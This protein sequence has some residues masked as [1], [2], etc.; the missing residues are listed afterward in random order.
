MNK[1]KDTFT[2]LA[3]IKL[4]KPIITLSVAFSALTGFVL[5]EQSFSPGW[6]SLYFGVLL[7]AAGSSVINQIQERSSDLLMERTRHRPL[8]SGEV[9]FIQASVWA[10]ILSISGMVILWF[11]A[12]P[13]ASILAIITLVWYNGIY[14][15]LK[16]FTSWAILPG[17]VVGAIP[18]AIGWTAAGNSL[19]HPHIIFLS[20]FF[21]IGQIPHFWLILLRYGEDYKKAGFPSI[22]ATLN[23]SQISRLTF[24][25]ITST[26]IA[27]MLLPFF[28]IIESSTIS[29][30]TI[31]L[32]LILIT[33][34][35]K[36]PGI[37]TSVYVNRAF[38]VMNIYFLL[39]MIL[40][41]TD[42]V[43]V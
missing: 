6:I 36:W 2:G 13:T 29:Y 1:N 10:G 35:F 23:Y 5:A 34:F 17:A 14:T 21:F 41:I 37:K 12:N 20:F 28:G 32:S 7:I 43:F 24:V 27:A 31:G 18:P 11:L 19:M 25:W 16:K 42:S 22:T 9:S 3:Y 30:I 4:T 38:F 39:I 15:P 33:S 26:A 40:I 8:P